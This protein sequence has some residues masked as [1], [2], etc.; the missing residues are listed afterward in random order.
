MRQIWLWKWTTFHFISEHTHCPS[1]SCD[2]TSVSTSCISEGYSTA[3]VNSPHINPRVKHHAPNLFRSISF[4]FIST[5]LEQAFG[6]ITTSIILIHGAWHEQWRAASLR[7]TR[8][9]TRSSIKRIDLQA[10]KSLDIE[11]KTGRAICLSFV[12]AILTL[13]FFYSWSWQ[14]T[15][16]SVGAFLIWHLISHR[17]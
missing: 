17:N 8:N 14:D 13:F 12:S 16:W 11:L 3:F 2:G 1:C 5:V 4:P 10:F 15:R 7:T 6:N 9:W